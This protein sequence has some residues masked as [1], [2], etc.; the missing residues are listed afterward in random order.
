MAKNYQWRT[1]MSILSGGYEGEEVGVTPPDTG[2]RTTDVVSGTSTATY[3]YRDSASRENRN[4]S[5]VAISVT[6]NWTANIDSRNNLTITTT[7]T[8]NSIVRD[9]VRGTVPVGSDFNIFI[10]RTSGGPNIW[11]IG[12]DPANYAHTILGSPLVVGTFTFTLAPGEDNTQATLFIRNNFVGHDNDGYG[13]PYVDAMRMGTEF[14]NILPADYRPGAIRDNSGVW[15][16]HNREGGEVHI[17]MPGGTWREER[18]IAGLVDHDNP[19]SIRM[20]DSW[21]NQRLIGKED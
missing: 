10:R 3:Y 13:S 15:L 6:E 5:R 9:D 7:T 14:K 21:Y 8:I 18:T 1:T 16:S 4:S 11:S 2:W 17:L 12:G 20:N 19:P